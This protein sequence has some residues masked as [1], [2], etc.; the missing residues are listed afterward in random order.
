MADIRPFAAR[1]FDSLILEKVVAGIDLPTF[2]VSNFLIYL[3]VIGG[4]SLE[5]M[6]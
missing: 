3:V 2:F 4:N 5:S 1:E 6:I